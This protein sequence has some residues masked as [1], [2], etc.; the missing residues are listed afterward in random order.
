MHAFIVLNAIPSIPKTEQSFVGIKEENGENFIIESIA[1]REKDILLL[2][3]PFAAQIS[4]SRSSFKS[5][6]RIWAQ[7]LSLNSELY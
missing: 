3:I 2:G 1:A 4:E 6:N 5:L 7:R